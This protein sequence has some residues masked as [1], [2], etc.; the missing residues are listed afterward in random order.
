MSGLRLSQQQK[1]K[2]IF[3]KDLDYKDY[4]Y[5]QTKEDKEFELRELWIK[6]R[7]QRLESSMSQKHK[8]EFAS[9][10]KEISDLI[11]SIRRQIDK[12]LVK[13]SLPPHF[14]N[15]I[16]FYDKEELLYDA[17]KTSIR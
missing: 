6:T 1:N 12:Y 2:D 9:L 3:N 8:V 7:K 14:G 5:M 4:F 10:N 11:R 13:N 15:Y 16:R 17:E